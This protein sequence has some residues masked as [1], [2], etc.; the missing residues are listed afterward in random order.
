V[1]GE[2]EQELREQLPHVQGEVVLVL[3]QRRHRVALVDEEDV[4]EGSRRK[5]PTNRSAI[6]FAR[7]ART[8]LDQLCM[9]PQPVRHVDHKGRSWSTVQYSELV[10][11]SASATGGRGHVFDDALTWDG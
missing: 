1:Q 8:G 10:A 3:G 2:L 5:L 6:A 4:V 11:V 9:P 7:L